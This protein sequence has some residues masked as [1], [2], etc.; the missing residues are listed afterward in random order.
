METPDEWNLKPITNISIKLVS[1]GT[2]STSNQEFW[3]GD[4]PWTKS[5]VLTQQY[6]DEGEQF[7]TKKGLQNSSSYFVPKNN[8][9]IASR[10]SLDL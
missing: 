8:L 2:P 7:I 3:N 1:G 6:I 4:I 5:A 9:L 10:V